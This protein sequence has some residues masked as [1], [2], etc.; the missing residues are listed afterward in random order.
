MLVRGHQAYVFLF[1]SYE[2]RKTASLFSFLGILFKFTSFKKIKKCIFY[3]SF[4]LT[5][6][7]KLNLVHHTTWGTVCY[8]RVTFLEYG[9]FGVDSSSRPYWKLSPASSLSWKSSSCDVIPMFHLVG[10]VNGTE[11][12]RS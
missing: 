1:W 11:P 3:R 12:S 6:A 8:F 5:I 10:A 7:F 2:I 9:Y 4:S